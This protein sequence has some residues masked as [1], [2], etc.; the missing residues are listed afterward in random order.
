MKLSNY[1]F[2]SVF[3]VFSILVLL[4]TA[5]LLYFYYVHLPKGKLKQIRAVTDRSLRMYY[6]FNHDGISERI[7]A[8]YDSS[9]HSAR[10]L[11]EEYNGHTIN[12]WGIPG[13]VLL[14]PLTPFC[15]IDFGDINN[16]GYD[17]LIVFSQQKDSL[18][19]YAIDIKN[20]EHNLGKLLIQRSYLLHQIKTNKKVKWDVYFNYHAVVDLNND[21][22]KE[23][24][25]TLVS[26]FGQHPRGIYVYDFSKKKI[27]ARYETNAS[28]MKMDFFDL[29]NDGNKEIIVSTYAGGNYPPEAK[30]SDFYSWIFVFDSK[31]RPLFKPIRLYGFTSSFRGAGIKNG[32]KKCIIGFVSGNAQN[33]EPNKLI[34]ID[35]DGNILKTVTLPE[36]FK[37]GD[38]RILK[39]SNDSLFIIVSNK[40]NNIVR[41]FD[42]QFRLIA[43]RQF[44]GGGISFKEIADLDGDGQMELIALQS[45]KLLILNLNLK[46]LASIEMRNGDNRAIV[47][48]GRNGDNTS[49]NICVSKKNFFAIFNY[50]QLPFYL[51]PQFQKM[52]LAWILLVLF[53]LLY[54][55]KGGELAVRW[56][57]IPQIQKTNSD[58]LLILDDLGQIMFYNT[59]FLAKVGLNFVPKTK[60]MYV[61]L[62]ARN[63]SLREL[64]ERSIKNKEAIK[65][66]IMLHHSDNQVSITPIRTWSGLVAGYWVQITDT[67]PHILD[68]RTKIWTS[69]IK[70]LAHDIKTPLSNIEIGV[71][72]VKDNI[73]RSNVP[74]KELLAEDLDVLSKEVKRITNEVRNFLKF[75]NL[76]K[77]HFQF[78][79]IHETIQKSLQNFAAYWNSNFEIELELAKEMPDFYF[80]PQQMEMVFNNLIKNALDALR[81]SGKIIIRTSLIQDE[82]SEKM[83][84]FCEIDIIDNGPGID[85][86][87]LTMIFE[88]EFSDKKDG[89]GMGLTIVKKIIEDHQGEIKVSSTIGI[90]TTFSILLPI[91]ENDENILN[92]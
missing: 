91:L 30:Q 55:H 37:I 70:K 58:G 80:D 34:K 57:A 41:V 68:E 16:D 44:D 63:S 53:L 25:F 45:Y 39:K 86:E 4:I 31:L 3:R 7:Q 62:F 47:T 42:Q 43:Q 69:T 8:F 36:I 59:P 23:L 26:G 13:K 82:I 11:I 76:E 33:N 79:N 1:S 88:P 71:R 87:K 12:D 21:N 32:E 61:N 56:K 46:P 85:K 52:F 14:K 18:F 64:I 78:A 38:I 50:S 40:K 65:A 15:W 10:F 48:I 83:Q 74:N 2:H 19:L 49:A 67:S 92:S 89:S 66:T 60:E 73:I 5:I 27:I 75:V 35:P 90:A 54:Y 22:H 6:D 20:S 81:D 51:M 84:K 17:D 28:L 9:R 24:V 29:N 77:P 72:T